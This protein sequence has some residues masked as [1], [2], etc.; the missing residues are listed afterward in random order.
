MSTEPNKKQLSKY[1]NG[2]TFSK[3][4]G[5]NAE[6]SRQGT[7]NKM[8]RECKEMI[9][10]CFEQLGGLEGLVKWAKSSDERLDAFYTRMYV[11]LLPFNLDIRSHKDAV[12]HNIQDIKDRFGQAGMTL[13]LI[14]RLR[15]R[16]QEQLKLIEHVRVD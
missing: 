5:R 14:E 10:S 3:G 2:G 4:D 6:R 9:A 16:E 13:E 15:K 8:S 12:Y 11:R 1:A 7:P